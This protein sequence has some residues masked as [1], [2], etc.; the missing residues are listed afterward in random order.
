MKSERLLDLI[1]EES[2][3]LANYVDSYGI[4]HHFTIVQSQKLDE[5]ILQYQQQIQEESS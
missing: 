5:L 2:K 3:A 4:E 1:Y